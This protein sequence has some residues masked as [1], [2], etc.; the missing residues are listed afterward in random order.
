[1]HYSGRDGSL[2]ADGVRVARVSNW[3]LSSSVETL[4]T[5]HLG[6]D[7]KTYIP[8][9]KSAQ[10]TCSIFYHDDDPVPLLKRVLTT[11]GVSESD[12]VR[13][14][15]R[16]GKKKVDIDAIITKADLTCQ[17]GAVM[18]A[19]LGFTVTGNYQDLAL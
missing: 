4:E 9:L 7:E 2:Y 16:W 18:Q 13:L 15:L 5:T 11:D 12:V 14:S 17:V 6:S 8:G 10:G 1:M 3:A 19:A